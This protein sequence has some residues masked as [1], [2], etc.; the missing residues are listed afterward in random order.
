MMQAAI[1][2]EWAHD[3]QGLFAAGRRYREVSLFYDPPYDNEV[4]DR[5]ARHLV[6]YLTPAASL[7]YKAR[8]WAAY[9]QC[10]FDFVIDLGTRRIALDYTGTPTDIAGALVEDNDALALGAG[11]V[12]VVF[13]VRGRDLDE[14]MYDCLHMIAQW[15]P[16]LFTPYGRRIFASRASIEARRTVAGLED[17]IV[18]VVFRAPAPEEV[19]AMDDLIEWPPAGAADDEI[20]LRRLSRNHPDYWRRQYERASLVYGVRD[21]VQSLESV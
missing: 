14:R 5:L 19:I 15:E 21:D 6:A 9:T 16:Q 18:S 2:G 1:H 17:D 7:D 3:H 12:D 10:R 11:V 4:D 20:V 8:I 13:R